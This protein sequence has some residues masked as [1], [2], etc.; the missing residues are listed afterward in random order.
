MN[1][2]RGFEKK[3]ECKV[4]VLSVRLEIMG[5]TCGV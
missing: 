4:E 3:K 2:G 1:L 5:V